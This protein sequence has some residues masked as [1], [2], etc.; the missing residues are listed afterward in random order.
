MKCPPQQA[1]LFNVNVKTDV[2]V[3]DV[4]SNMLMQCLERLRGKC[5]ESSQTMIELDMIKRALLR[6]QST[7]RDIVKQIPILKEEMKV[8]DAEMKH[9]KADNKSLQQLVLQKVGAGGV[10]RP[11]LKEPIPGISSQAVRKISAITRIQD[12]PRHVFRQH[13]PECFWA[14]V[15][16]H[17]QH[18]KSD[19]SFLIDVHSSLYYRRAFLT[20]EADMYGIETLAD[21]L[22]LYKQ[23]CVNIRR[24]FPKKQSSPGARPHGVISYIGTSDFT[25]EFKNPAVGSVKLLVACSSFWGRSDPSAIVNRK[26]EYFCTRDAPEQ[27]ITVDF[28]D[29][30]VIP[31]SYSF[32]SFH[33]MVAGYYPR[34]WVFE[35]SLDGKTWSL[36]RKHENDTTLCKSNKWGLWETQLAGTEGKQDLDI[37]SDVF[38]H[39][40][41]QFFRYFRIRQTGQNSFGSHELQL[42]AIEIY[43]E[44]IAITK[45]LQTPPPP[46]L[47][48]RD[49]DVKWDPSWST[50]PDPKKPKEKKRNT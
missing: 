11:P 19:Y 29:K 49:L 8:M 42:T 15:V 41:R 43:G 12:E 37:D 40:S 6:M 13:H 3:F 25:K 16:R 38:E 24:L 7:V 33:P 30:V 44:V 50:L 1:S 23:P 48:S 34:D 14:H 36:L 22:F 27:W 17:L 46:A 4:E 39:A 21:A 47:I 9:L 26:E 10:E 35:A 28:L 20:R 18:G 32:A 45:L 2:K 31:H 5:N